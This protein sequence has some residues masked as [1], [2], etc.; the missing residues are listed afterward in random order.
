MLV[1][2][3]LYFVFSS[4]GSLAAIYFLTNVIRDQAPKIKRGI[5]VSNW[6][7]ANELP[8]SM[9]G[10][11]DDILTVCAALCNFKEPIYND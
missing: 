5:F 6:C 3:C 7:I 8:I 4:N 11:V 2:C 9:L 10:Q 1:A